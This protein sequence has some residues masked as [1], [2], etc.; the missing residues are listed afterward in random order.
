M[1]KPLFFTEH[2]RYITSHHFTNAA[3]TYRKMKDVFPAGKP[4]VTADDQE[5]ETNPNQPT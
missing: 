1:A 2:T 4:D 5:P 3:N